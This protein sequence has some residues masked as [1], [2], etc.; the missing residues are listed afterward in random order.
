MHGHHH[1]FRFPSVYDLMSFYFEVINSMYIYIYKNH[2]CVRN[3]FKEG[4]MSSGT[5]FAKKGEW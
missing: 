2:T 1:S 4:I 3:G 5:Q